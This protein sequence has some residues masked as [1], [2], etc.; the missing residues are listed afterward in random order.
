MVRRAV[1]TFRSSDPG[2][3]LWRG[4]AGPDARPVRVDVGELPDGR[5][6]VRA[7]ADVVPGPDEV[8]PALARAV[9]LEHDSLVSGASACSTARSPSRTASR[10]GTRSTSRKCAW[11]SGP[12]AGR[13]ARSSRAS[14]SASRA[15]S[16]AGPA[17][18]RRRTSAAAS[19]RRWSSSRSASRC[20]CA[21]IYGGFEHDD[22]W[23]LHAAFGST[24][25]FCAVR[26]YVENS[27]SVI[28]YS[29]VLLDVDLTDELALDVHG[30]AEASP[31]ARFAYF[32][33]QRELWVEH[34]LLADDLQAEELKTAVD[35]VAAVADGNDDRLQAA[36]GG[37]RYAD[38]RET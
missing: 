26:H 15:A 13:Q 21:H 9:L 20:S 37:R 24:R 31:G 2:D 1:G 6:F 36:Y 25:V 35:I 7:I 17:R 27:A 30:V 8:S 10:A 28:V 34:A 5:P 11:P 12:P 3:S 22:T 14:P 16:R 38:L 18:R 19:T 23:G 32:P 4:F 29:P 33:E